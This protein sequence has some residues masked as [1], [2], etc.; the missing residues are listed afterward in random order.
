M[1]TELYPAMLNNSS[2]IDANLLRKANF[3]SYSHCLFS[4]P[5]TEYLTTSS[6]INTCEGKLV[7]RTHE[8]VHALAKETLFV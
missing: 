2:K 1:Y 3:Q 5:C 4:S 7:D 8:K 6:T